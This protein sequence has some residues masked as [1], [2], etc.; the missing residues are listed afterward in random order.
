MI[1]ERREGIREILS[2]PKAAIIY[3]ESR[4]K[5]AKKCGF[6]SLVVNVF[7]MSKKG[8]MVQSSFKFKV[9]ST[10][11]MRLWHPSKKIWVPIKGKVKWINSVPSQYGNYFSGIAFNYDIDKKESKYDSGYVHREGIMSPEILEF[12]L[13]TNFLKSI[14]SESICPLLNSLFYR[15]VKAGE[16]FIIQGD[17]GNELF[18]IYKGS[19]IVSIEKE[20]VK[21]QVARLIEGDI[22]G[23]MAILTGELRTTNVEAETDM[24]LW[25]ITREDFDRISHSYPDIRNFLTEIVAQRFESAKVTSERTIGKYVINEIAGH[26]G[27]SVVYKGFHKVLNFPVAIKML[28]HNLAM[29]QEF[30]SRFRDEAKTIAKLD[31]MNIVKVYDIEE[32]YRTIFIVMEYLTGYTLEYQLERLP[33]MSVLKV[34]DIILQVCAGLQYAH[35]HGVIHQDIK[36]ANIFIMPDGIVKIVDFGLACN[37]G[38][39]DYNLPGTIYYMSP[40][41]IEGNPVDERTDIYSLGIMMFEMLT[42]R[43]PFPEDN[44]SV[45]MDL[46]LKE[47]VPSPCEIEKTIKKPLCDIVVKCSKRDPNER[48]K[49]VDEVLKELEPIAKEIG[50]NYRKGA[51]EKINMIG[52]YLFYKE[53]H[54]SELNKLIDSFYKNANEIVTDFKVTNIGSI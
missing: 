47:D 46:H 49:S 40:E 35:N 28:K 43:R 41:Q 21:H 19:C 33:K 30:L 18:I 6:D 36:P 12:L 38:N 24:E 22:V 4:K 20:G 48:Y 44:L 45:L 42:G 32:L 39:I 52:I 5:A 15:R 10:I 29:D 8:V 7:N 17:V 51:D 14:P 23:E 37:V 9:N 53:K 50:V 13:S 27:W 2:P 16:R 1:G 26:G 34:L 3:T 54:K 25:G 31:H 11:D